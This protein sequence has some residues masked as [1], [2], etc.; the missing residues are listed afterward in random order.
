MKNYCLH[1]I[2]SNR[3]KDKRFTGRT[4]QQ[5]PPPK[6]NNYLN[7]SRLPLGEEAALTEVSH[8]RGPI[9]TRSPPQTK[10]GTRTIRLERRLHPTVYAGDQKK[11]RKQS[12][13]T[14]YKNPPTRQ[15]FHNFHPRGNSPRLN[16]GHNVHLPQ[17]LPPYLVDYR[18]NQPPHGIPDPPHPLASN[19]QTR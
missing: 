14:G 13:P 1:M 6:T 19:T 7:L 2:P 12:Q 18:L 16:L 15:H 5:M 8:Y 4:E 9:S 11:P 17:R 3:A 10:D